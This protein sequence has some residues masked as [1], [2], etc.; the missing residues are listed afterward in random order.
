MDNQ[1]YNLTLEELI[2]QVKTDLITREYVVCSMDS[3][4]Y[5]IELNMPHK[6]DFFSLVL[7]EEG[8]CTYKVNDNKSR[9]EAN[10]VLF[11][12]ISETFII[13]HISDDYKAKYILF[14]TN[15]ITQAGFN[16]RSNDILKSISS[17]PAIII[18]NEIAL[19]KRLKF[20]L[21]ELE[22]LNDAENKNYYFNELI[23][24]SFS[25]LIYEI[26]NYFRK[27]EIVRPT[28]P[29][30]E[31]LTTRFFEL[32]RENYKEHHDV[33]F[34]AD[35]LFVTR[36]YLS[37]MIKKTMLKSSREI[38]NHLLVTEAKILLRNYNTSVS[39][40]ATELKFS[41]QSVFSKFFKK[42]TGQTPSDYK[43]DDLY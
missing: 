23:W 4:N 22:S 5:N 14:T 31:D 40:A 39:D 6:A 20:Y 27:I 41:D 35:S 24:H 29:R 17:N 43:K 25:L 13:D 37:K 36:K 32:L 2:N 16:Y 1:V 8:F 11:S 9:V 3:T 28:T 18:N 12:P 21:D 33:Q 42:H 34:Y 15:F 26:D 7:I 19:F 38:I 30:G 10:D